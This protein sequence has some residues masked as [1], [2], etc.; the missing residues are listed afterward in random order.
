[1]KKARI[2]TALLALLMLAPAA[3]PAVAAT[4]TG[5]GTYYSGNVSA[6][7]PTSVTPASVMEAGTWKFGYPVV[8][9]SITY[10]ANGTPTGSFEGYYGNGRWKTIGAAPANGKLA[11][12]G[13]YSFTEIRYTGDPAEL[14]DVS[15]YGQYLRGV[16]GDLVEYEA[17]SAVGTPDVSDTRTYANSAS[18]GADKLFDHDRT[19]AT[20]INWASDTSNNSAPA[21]VAVKL[22]KPT[23]ITEIVYYHNL[24][25]GILHMQGT[26]EVSKDGQ[27]WYRYTVNHPLTENTGGTELGTVIS[28]SVYTSAEWAANSAAIKADPYYHGDNSSKGLSTV[29]V[30]WRF[31]FSNEYS[32]Y[33]VSARGD[34]EMWQQPYQ[35]VR[36]YSPNGWTFAAADVV[37]YGVDLGDG[38]TQTN[39]YTYDRMPAM[40]PCTLVPITE[41]ELI[42]AFDAP[43]RVTSIAWAAT[44]SIAGGKWYGA[45]DTG[46][47]WKEITTMDGTAT[48]GTI[49][50]TD[51]IAYRYVKFVGNGAAV[52]T[53]SVQFTGLSYPTLRGEFIPFATNASGQAV[54]VSGGITN[55]YP[56]AAHAITNIYRYFDYEATT[57]AQTPQVQVLKP[58]GATTWP[59][60]VGV[61]LEKPTVIS[62][63]FLFQDTEGDARVR[64]GDLQVSVDGLHWVPFVMKGVTDG[65]VDVTPTYP[66]GYTIS[67][68][69]H[70][71][72][73]TQVHAKQGYIFHADLTNASMKQAYRY[74][75]LY[76]EARSWDFS[77]SEM[78]VY[79]LPADPKTVMTSV[80][81]QGIGITATTTDPATV[82][83]KLLDAK[84]VTLTFANAT[85]FTSLSLT[86]G[87]DLQVQGS[88]DGE[89]WLNLNT[90]VASRAGVRG[91][92]T[93]GSTRAI[94]YLRFTSGIGVASNSITAIGY[95][96]G[97]TGKPLTLDYSTIET[98]AGYYQT[99]E[100]RSHNLL[101]SWNHNR[102][103]LTCA[104]NDT[105]GGV[106]HTAMLAAPSVIT[107]VMLWPHTTY[108]GRMDKVHIQA[109]TAEEPDN[110]VTLYLVDIYDGTT[111]NTAVFG[112]S[113]AGLGI[114]TTGV[115]FTISDDTAYSYFRLYKAENGGSYQE[116]LS[117]AAFEVFGEARPDNPLNGDDTNF[118]W[119]ALPAG[120]LVGAGV[121]G[122]VIAKKKKRNI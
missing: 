5:T 77:I 98:A 19:T 53:S 70:E 108:V 74:V 28:Q 63:I 10:T 15:F 118:A 105:V 21:W 59:M 67:V 112:A 33:T 120:G 20:K 8:L 31:S 121:A 32:G 81:N 117:I 55:T 41:S 88:M 37:V 22:E 103:T 92:I 82:S 78:N 9:W 122:V 4:I 11:Y 25:S 2:F 16:T 42:W 38:T 36:F 99:D 115:K 102:F 93:V 58:S 119:V 49:S 87:A 97:I 114:N 73:T 48:S 30:S 57:G 64:F 113:G 17:G 84:E 12:T 75:R 71:N 62:E 29:T 6:Q 13:T 83:A 110:W 27:T 50:V 39:E 86:A 40:A 109:A 61:K 96:P 35:Y 94:R 72:G 101:R 24:G 43:T 116:N 91:V 14:N 23:I 26:F 111:L 66:E 65:S 60:Y 68:D 100:T 51:S 18:N 69:K 79:G 89:T 3:V 106:A 52:T 90:R 54:T 80:Y 104:T 7:A 85:I 76:R 107:E 1:M 46:L 44:E 95:D 56:S 34:D 47:T 45:S